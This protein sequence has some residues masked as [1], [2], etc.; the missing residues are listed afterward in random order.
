MFL[1]GDQ[2]IMLREIWVKLKKARMKTGKI[3][4]LKLL[5]FLTFDMF[6]IWLKSY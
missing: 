4:I 6:L 1:V 2:E 3:A 5:F